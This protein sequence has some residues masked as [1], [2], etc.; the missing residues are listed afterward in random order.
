MRERG[1]LGGSST[2]QLQRVTHCHHTSSNI[3]TCVCVV[4]VCVGC[5]CVCLCA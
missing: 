3:H 4:C 1:E 5:V 2:E